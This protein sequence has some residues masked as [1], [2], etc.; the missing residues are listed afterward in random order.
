MLLWAA[1]IC[2][3]TPSVF[4]VPWKEL[5]SLSGEL[6]K[7]TSTPAVVAV[8]AAVV[9]VFAAVVAVFLTQSTATPGEATG[10]ARTADFVVLGVGN[11]SQGYLEAGLARDLRN[12]SLAGARRNQNW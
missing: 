4:S 1:K 7:N 11:G 8:F 5:Y 9:A 3:F 2:I 12:A 6:W 10:G